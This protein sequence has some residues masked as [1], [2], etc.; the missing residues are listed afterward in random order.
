MQ[1]QY[2]RFRGISVGNIM[3]CSLGAV[4]INIRTY[5]YIYIYTKTWNVVGF[6][7]FFTLFVLVQFLFCSILENQNYLRLEGK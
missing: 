4:A 1:F 2:F 3:C 5:I 6:V 7:D